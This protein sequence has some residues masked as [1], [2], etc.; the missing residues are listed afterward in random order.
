M[1][2]ISFIIDIILTLGLV[3]VAMVYLVNEFELTNIDMTGFFNKLKRK[4]QRKKEDDF[5]KDY[6]AF[7]GKQ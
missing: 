6:E 5:L 2:I 7:F 4:V 1:M 3:V